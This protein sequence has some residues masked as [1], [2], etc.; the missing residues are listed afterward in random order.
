MSGPL[1]GRS[2][3]LSGPGVEAGVEINVESLVD[4]R[5]P[6]TPQLRLLGPMAIERDGVPLALPSSRKVRALIAYLA[7]AARPLARDALCELL[8]DL[9][10]DP[11][12]ELRWCLSKA[13]AL[14]DEP[15]HPRLLTE[16]DTV[17][18]DIRALRVDAAEILAAVQAGVATLEPERLM[19]LE[20]LWVGGD[21]LQGLEIERSAPYSAWLLAQRRRLRAAHVAILDQL[22]HGDQ[23]PGPEAEARVI[24]R[25]EQWLAL[26]PFDRR[27]H[28]GLLDALARG[29]RLHEG[30]EHLDAT[31]RR[32][33]AEGQD[34]APIGRA[35]QAAKARHAMAAASAPPARA[36]ASPV[37][38]DAAWLRLTGSEAAPP[39][40]ATEPTP[41]RASV[42]VLPFSEHGSNGAPGMLRGGLADGLVHD[43]ITR[44]A[45]LRSL[46]VIAQGTVFALDAQRVGPD[47]AGRAL[48][49]D[50]VASGQLQRRGIGGTGP[51]R[52][53]S[54]SVQ[55]TET[56]SARI[57]W[58]DEFTARDGA[59]TFE[60][61]EQIGNR[62]VAAI[63]Q[64]I[65][66]AERNRAILKPPSSLDAWEAHHR[67]LWHM[68]RFN[69]EDNDQARHWFEA[70]I[71]LDP[72]FARP[73]AGL[74]FTHFQNAFLGW[75][76]REPAVEQA[77]RIAS[78]G[79]M[80]DE[81]DP[82]VHWAL[83]RAL[84]LRGRIG[85][86]LAELDTS[87]ALSP[88]FAHGHYTL[89]FIHSQS[90]DAATALREADHSRE[91][92]PYDPLLFAMQATRAMALM[93]LGRH[94]EAAEWS[95]KA[96]ARPNAHAHILAIA[97]HCL[98]LAGRGDEARAVSAELQRRLPGYRVD[99]LLGA[100]RF[101]PDVVGVLRGVSAGIG[102]G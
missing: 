59:Q 70:A 12:G 74:S 73:Y 26:A 96:V 25:L 66:A 62:I 99:D 7:L 24:A 71:R 5:L 79:L 94:A 75:G 1:P 45:K 37:G 87:V 89:G 57:V 13:R 58:A 14:L 41:R 55:L 33:E 4:P 72:T 46:F 52:G 44:L 82:A 20:A 28:E 67:G 11:R 19:A 84:W 22:V 90:G 42:A 30:D 17:R 34:W 32:F 98:A 78:Q 86:S 35:W 95:L 6:L 21:F 76:E 63:D 15:G 93:R 23:P 85:E 48:N 54:V 102:L 38:A 91:L 3:A 97:A 27:A 65:E 81:R 83:G 8:W 101:A 51:H 47:E 60:V 100:F 36:P 39:P 68:V 88:N 10:N 64:Q 40:A 43:V 77:Y 61:I 80:T 49:V 29:G 92:S 9:P 53:F 31:A 56:R 16:G 18:L 50:Y 69:R 2:Q